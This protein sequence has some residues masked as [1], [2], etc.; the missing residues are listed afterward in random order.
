MKK[1]VVSTGASVGQV[2]KTPRNNTFVC[3]VYPSLLS[4]NPRDSSR[5]TYGQ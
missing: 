5:N 2:T 1:E 3:F 4:L